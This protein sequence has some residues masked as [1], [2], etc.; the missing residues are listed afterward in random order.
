MDDND[1]VQ[2]LKRSYEITLKFPAMPQVAAMLEAIL[3]API[4]DKVLGLD[5]PKSGHESPKLGEW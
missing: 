2:R 1:K 3:T 4:D 5:S